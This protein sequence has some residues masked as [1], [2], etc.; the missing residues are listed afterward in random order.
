MSDEIR[1]LEILEQ[2]TLIRRTLLVSYRSPIH[3]NPEL[4]GEVCDRIVR[5]FHLELSDRSCLE[6]SHDRDSDRA[7]VIPEGMGSDRIIPSGPSFIDLPIPSDEVI[8]ADI[9]P[10]FR[11]RMIII[12]RSHD[13]F[14]TP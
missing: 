9:P 8:I 2:T 3:I 6:V 1:H 7:L 12:D 4:L 14:I 11:D 5:S 13:L 10:S